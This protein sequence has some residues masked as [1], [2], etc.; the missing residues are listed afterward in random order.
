MRQIAFAGRTFGESKIGDQRLVTFIDQNVGW[1]QVAMQ[2]T[3]LVGMVNGVSHRA[4]KFCGFSFF[5]KLIDATGKRTIADVL[6][7]KK[8]LPIVLTGFKDRHD[9]RV[10]KFRRGLGFDLE[11]LHL[12]RR[13]EP[14][15]ENH[16]QRDDSVK[17]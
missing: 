3:A 14:A 1:F 12:I 8:G 13:R 15:T 16:F 5:T 10:V 7:C 11:S 2:D 6:H 9:S 17:L 4:N